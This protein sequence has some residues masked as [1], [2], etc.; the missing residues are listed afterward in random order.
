[1]RLDRVTVTVVENLRDDLLKKLS[2]KRVRRILTI[3]AAVFK[4]AQRRG[5]ATTNPAALAA[6]PRDPVLEV[7]G[8]D[9]SNGARVPG[10]CSTPARSRA[11]SH[12]R[13][14]PVAHHVR[15][16]GQYRV[17]VGRNLRY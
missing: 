11:C 8:S 5:F 7:D 4:S 15:D 2:P 9:E 10:T 12:T 3:A 14:R 13:R 17:E 6:R 1:M 16:G